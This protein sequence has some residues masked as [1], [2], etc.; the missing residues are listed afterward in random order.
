MS[1]DET[2][3]Q[4]T[5][6][7]T[8]SEGTS[9]VTRRGLLKNGLAMAGSVAAIAAGAG[10]GSAR[11]D[12]SQPYSPLYAQSGSSVA[13]RKFRAWVS[14]GEGSGR[15]S[16]Q[17]LTLR[18]IGGRQVVVRTEAANLCYTLS[19]PM[20]GITP[21]FQ[22]TGRPLTAE[23]RARADRLNNMATVQGHGGVGI[24]EAVGPEVRRVKVGDRVCVSG[25]P[26]CGVCYAC[27]RGRSDMCQFLG[28]ANTPEGMTPVADMRD[29]TPVYMNSQIGGFGEYMVTVEEW[30]VPIITQASAAHL[31]VACACTSVAGLGATTSQGIAV[32]PPA[33]K[34]AVVGCGPLGL[35]AIQGAR[36]AGAKMIIGVDPIRVR[37]E[38][39]MKVGAS[40]V[41]DPNE[42]GDVVDKVRELTSEQNPSMWG[43]GIYSAPFQAGGADFVVEAAGGEW[44]P[45]ALERGPDPTGLLPMQQAYDML[46]GTGHA[47]LT[48][49][50]FGNLSFNAGVFALAGRSVHAGQAGGCSPL[51]DI[52]KFVSFLDNGSF[53][54][55][56]MLTAPVPLEK[57]LDTYQEVARRATILAVL[58]V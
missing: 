44:L 36:I 23:Q 9:G 34:V 11:A 42:P 1:A 28:P 6:N 48:S 27:L 54:P 29:G 49:L 12:D 4:D 56:A 19:Q 51:R 40:H 52:P 46:H 15:T 37:R 21:H 17:E 45:P 53:D 26:Q 30:V 41:L 47:V 24:V 20:L 13:G 2:G 55:T 22:G 39:A 35:S 32:L 50:A 57:V 43:G 8:G 33:A 3:N 5:S 7:A 10:A 25:T 58:V 38:A 31:E 14:R 18:P 16:L